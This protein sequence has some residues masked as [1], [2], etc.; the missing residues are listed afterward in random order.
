MISHPG[1]LVELN[2]ILITKSSF[3]HKDYKDVE[4]LSAS[5]GIF[6]PKPSYRVNNKKKRS[7]DYE[8]GN[9]QVEPL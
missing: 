1:K 7:V 9:N 2:T 8:R 4:Y 3:F 6:R 5:F